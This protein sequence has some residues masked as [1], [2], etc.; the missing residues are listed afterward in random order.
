MVDAISSGQSSDMQMI[1]QMMKNHKPGDMFKQM[2]LDAGGD[3]SSITKQQLEDLSK[4]AQ[5]DGKDTKMLD[6]L[7][8]NF[9]KISNGKDSDG[10]SVIKAD[11][12]E[13]AMKNGTLKPPGGGPKGPRPSG[14]PPEAA[15]S[16]QAAKKSDGNSSSSSTKLTKDQLQNYLNQFKALNASDSDTAKQIQQAI[17]NYGQSSS[18]STLTEAGIQKDI[19]DLK[20]KASK[21]PQD[22]STVT[23]DQLEPPIDLRV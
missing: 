3:G 1:Q 11:D 9:D 23:K 5:A 13:K 2:S 20:T 18:S 16:S 12:I 19:N 14:P 6:D 22:P 21:E 7:A 8:K 15:N 17:S 4:K 10:N